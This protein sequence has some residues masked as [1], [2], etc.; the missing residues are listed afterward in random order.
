MSELGG[1]TEAADCPDQ[2]RLTAT[3]GSAGFQHAGVQ[4]ISKRDKQSNNIAATE[5]N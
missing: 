3:Q 2:N 5:P 4:G 1:P